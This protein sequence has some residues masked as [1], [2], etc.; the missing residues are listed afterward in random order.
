MDCGVKRR[1]DEEIIIATQSL[2]RRDD[3]V[4]ILKLN[5]SNR[6]CD[7]TFMIR[8]RILPAILALAIVAIFCILP[9]F[10]ADA[11]GMWSKVAGSGQGDVWYVDQTLTYE[12]KHGKVTNA[13]GFLKCVPGQDSDL[14]EQIRESLDVS[15]VVSGGFNY[16]IGS[17]TI[18]C[19]TRLMHFSDIKFFDAEDNIIFRA[20]YGER[21]YYASI[22]D[23]PSEALAH[24]LCL[25]KS[26]FLDTLKKQEP[27]L[28][29]FPK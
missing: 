6:T 4:A 3:G 18:N 9:V 22:A 5:T 27:F 14:G 10:N 1:D 12:D 26:G 21:E 2:K 20:E 25:D 11:K 28:Y 15:G 17:V 19:R 8:S 23:H 24:Y 29:L 7:N 16:F 13:R